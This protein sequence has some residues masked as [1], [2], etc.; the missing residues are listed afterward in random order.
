M[1]YGG[2][3]SLHPME[4]GGR[5]ENAP[6]VVILTQQHMHLP[7]TVVL[8]SDDKN[9]KHKRKYSDCREYSF[10]RDSRRPWQTDAIMH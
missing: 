4:K 3:T 2:P 9:T 7:E 1:K 6:A 10:S 5:L 8:V